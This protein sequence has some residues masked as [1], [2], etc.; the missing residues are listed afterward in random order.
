MELKRYSLLNPPA[1]RCDAVEAGNSLYVSGLVADDRGGS[2]QE[3]ARQTLEKL[4]QVLSAAGTDK[5]MVIWANV[6]LQEIGDY[7]SFNQVWNSWIAPDS[8]PAR[9]CVGAALAL[10]GAKVEIAVIAQK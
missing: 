2:I 1:H 7:D 3:Q 10:P 6:W 5:S 9:A 8:A 4:D